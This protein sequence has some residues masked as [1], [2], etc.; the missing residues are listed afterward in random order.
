MIPEP[1]TT[2]GRRRIVVTVEAPHQARITQVSLALTEQ[3][4][5]VEHVLAELGMITCT[6]P[7]AEHAALAGAVEGV[8]SVED[9]LGYQLPPPDSPVQ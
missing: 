1:Q 6:V 5:V 8:A 2:S 3:G 9:E 7:D 4:V